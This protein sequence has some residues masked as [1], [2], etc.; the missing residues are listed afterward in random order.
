MLALMLEAPKFRQMVTEKAMKSSRFLSPSNFDKY[1][2]DLMV[3]CLRFASVPGFVGN[4]AILQKAV[5]KGYSTANGRTFLE[6][7]PL[8]ASFL[9][10]CQTL[11]S[12][13]NALAILPSDAAP[14]RPPSDKSRPKPEGL[15]ANLTQGSP[16]A[17]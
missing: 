8:Q 14:P 6:G 5:V 2:Q 1:C 10:L 7:L 15:R 3:L 11:I 4:M 17:V 12:S 13:K 9:D 16:P